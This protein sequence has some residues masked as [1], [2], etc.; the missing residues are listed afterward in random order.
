MKEVETARIY[1]GFHYHHSVVE[2][3][4]LGREVGHQL[5]REFFQPSDEDRY[6]NVESDR[7]RT[8]KKGARSGKESFDSRWSLG[9]RIE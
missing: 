4:E 3:R 1:A 7:A 8:Q 5:A 9:S 6:G 2:G